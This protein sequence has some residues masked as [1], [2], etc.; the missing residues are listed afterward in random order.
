MKYYQVNRVYDNSIIEEVL[1]LNVEAN[2]KEEAI[3]VL[4][5]YGFKVVDVDDEFERIRVKG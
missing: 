2:T 1:G 3:E 5:N 4:E